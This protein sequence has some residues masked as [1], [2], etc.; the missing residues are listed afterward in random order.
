MRRSADRIEK[1]VN[2]GERRTRILVLISPSPSSQK[3][4]RVAARTAEAFHCKFSAMYVETNGA[5]SD[6][7]AANLKKH[8]NLVR[9][10]GGEIIVK[11]SDDVVETVA[12]YVL[13]L[14][15]HASYPR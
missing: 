8:M 5:L 11:Y 15:R 6:E 7:A 9:D 2:H 10:T 12:D 1:Q 14:Q 13:A 4:I 3:T